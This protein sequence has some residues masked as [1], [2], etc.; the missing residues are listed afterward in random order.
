VELL[1]ATSTLTDVEFPLLSQKGSEPIARLNDC[2]PSRAF[3]LIHNH[4]G[5]SQT[6]SGSRIITTSA[7]TDASNVVK[8]TRVSGDLLT[9]IGKAKMSSAPFATHPLA[10]RDWTQYTKAEH[11]LVRR[12]QKSNPMSVH[13]VDSKKFD[14]RPARTS[15]GITKRQQA[16]FDRQPR[17]GQV[18]SQ[19]RPGNVK[20]YRTIQFAKGGVL[21]GAGRLLPVIGWGYYGYHVAESSDPYDMIWGD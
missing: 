4:S 1:F 11:R 5:I 2:Y 9:R 16:H 17:R 19:L 7:V 13:K 14:Y 8:S 12:R 6:N 10:N 21:V 20:A 18:K 3:C 15:R